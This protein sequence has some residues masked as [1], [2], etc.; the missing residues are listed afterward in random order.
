MGEF[1]K[2]NTGGRRNEKPLTE[3]QKKQAKDYAVSLGMPE[4]GIYFLEH[5]RTSYGP[6]TDVLIIGTDVLPLEKRVKVPNSNISWKGALAHELTGHREA[7]LKGLTQPEEL[8][9]EVQA[10]IRAARFAEGLSDGERRDLVKDAVDRLR[11]A[12]ETLRRVKNGL[13]IDRR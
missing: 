8:L 5:T 13:N 9:E 1:R 3:E 2:A 11:K 12:G 6:E 4:D 10:S 7:E